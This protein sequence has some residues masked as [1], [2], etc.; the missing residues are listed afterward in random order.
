MIY[1]SAT[2]LTGSSTE[3][4]NGTRISDQG[5]FEEGSRRIGRSRIRVGQLR[6][7]LF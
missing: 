1:L 2:H 4:G 6:R 3:I 7:R 5:R